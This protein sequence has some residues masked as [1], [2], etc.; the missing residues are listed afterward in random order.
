MKASE[1]STISVVDS[2]NVHSRKVYSVIIFDPPGKQKQA[3]GGSIRRESRKDPLP[4]RF[5]QTEFV[6]QLALNGSVL[7]LIC[8][9]L[10]Y[11]QWQPSTKIGHQY[12]QTSV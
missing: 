3:C 7:Q 4:D 11:K 9:S 5:K 2:R 10:P 6:Q 12:E 8:L 1:L